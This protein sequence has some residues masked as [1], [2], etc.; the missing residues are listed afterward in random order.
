MNLA[1]PSEVFIRGV[2]RRGK[3]I[4]GHQ[5][6]GRKKKGHFEEGRRGKTAVPDRY[7]HGAAGFCALG[8]DPSTGDPWVLSLRHWA[9]SDDL[10]HLALDLQPAVATSS[11]PL[12]SLQ[13]FGG[14]GEFWL[15]KSPRELGQRRRSPAGAAPQGRLEGRTYPSSY[16]SMKLNRRKKKNAIR[17]KKRPGINH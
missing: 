6:Q 12:V 8:Q 17:R 15:W 5:R 13:G 7:N 10:F 14:K 11:P 2:R 1:H 4:K 3:V 16:K 9:K